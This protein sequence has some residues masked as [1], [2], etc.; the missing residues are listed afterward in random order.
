MLKKSVFHGDEL[1]RAR[2]RG[3]PARPAAKKAAAKKLAQ[4][5]ESAPRVSVVTAGGYTVF[6]SPVQ[7][8]HRTTKQIAA[9]VADLD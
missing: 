4:R 5:R 7:P 9:A 3:A 1:P 6:G 2:G 8:A